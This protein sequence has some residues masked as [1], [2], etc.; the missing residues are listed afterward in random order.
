[1][2]ANS[3]GYCVAWR[4]VK[5]WLEVQLAMVQ[6]GLVKFEQ[7][8]LPYAQDPKTGQTVYEQLKEKQF[9]SLAL[10]EGKK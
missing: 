3:R 8:F 5:D 4:I 10:T 9:S 2:R 6:A 1:L 7:V